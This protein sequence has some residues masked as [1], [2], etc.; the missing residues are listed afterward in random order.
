MALFCDTVMNLLQINEASALAFCLGLYCGF[1]LAWKKIYIQISGHT[2]KSFNEEEL[3]EKALKVT[4]RMKVLLLGILVISK[5][6][7]V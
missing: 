2:V 7:H 3:F 4:F 5:Y 6:S 1:R